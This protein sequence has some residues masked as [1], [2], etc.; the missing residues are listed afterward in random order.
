MSKCVKKHGPKQLCYGCVGKY[1]NPDKR[2]SHPP[3]RDTKKK[4]WSP[5]GYCWSYASHV[6]GDK[7]FKNMK[8]IC[9][10]CDLWTGRK[11]A[12]VESVKPKEPK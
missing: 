3:V 2:C 12:P 10:G 5:V 11:P 7:R 9:R 6:D 8:E 1:Q 4:T